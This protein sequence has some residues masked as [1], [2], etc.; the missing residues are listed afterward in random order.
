MEI[1][2]YLNK[3]KAGDTRVFCDFCGKEIDWHTGEYYRVKRAFGLQE[4]VICTECIESLKR[5]KDGKQD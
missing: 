1:G 3:E 4:Y 2:I 5:R